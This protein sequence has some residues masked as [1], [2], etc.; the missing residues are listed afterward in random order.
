MTTVSLTLHGDPEDVDS[1]AR[2]LRTELLDLDVD[3]ADFA[4]GGPAPELSK[5]A[6][7]D[8]VSTIIVALTT[9]P[10]LV[11]LGRV[12]RDWVRRDERRKIEVRDG[13]RSIVLTNTTAEDNSAAIEAFFRREPGD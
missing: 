11:Q 10:V 2:Q 9:S 6:D 4:A 8:T 3:S 7:A 13:D 12:L 5:G 1:Q